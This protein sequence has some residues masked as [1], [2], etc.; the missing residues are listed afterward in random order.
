E[1]PTAL[2]RTIDVENISSKPYQRMYA[3]GIDSYQL[4]A[5]LRQLKEIRSSQVFGETGSLKLNDKQQ[6]ER[7]TMLAEI[8]N[9]QAQIIPIVEQSSSD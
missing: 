2:H 1:K 7:Q 6:I 9:S 5:R 8:K 3:L 4:H